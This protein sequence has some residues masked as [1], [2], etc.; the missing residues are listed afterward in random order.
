M[1]TICDIYSSETVL[2]YDKIVFNSN[3]FFVIPSLGQLLEGWLLICSKEHVLSMSR[4]DHEALVELQGLIEE[5]RNKLNFIYPNLTVFEHGPNKPNLNSGCGIDHFHLHI[6]P[7]GDMDLFV[8][9]KKENPE[10]VWHRIP[11]LSDIHKNVTDTLSYLYLELPSGEKYITLKT[12][13]ESQYFRK[14]ISKKLGIPEKYDWRKYP[15]LTLIKK[16]INNLQV[17]EGYHNN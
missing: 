7:L 15:R 17:T 5:I 9:T 13:F 10:W 14:L 12:D 8:E 1:C 2:D 16:A 3:R 4:L 6:V 11:V